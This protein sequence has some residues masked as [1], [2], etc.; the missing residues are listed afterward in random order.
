MGVKATVEGE[1]FNNNLEI[2]ERG[3]HGTINNWSEFTCVL[4]ELLF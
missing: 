3:I 1:E 4:F 2:C